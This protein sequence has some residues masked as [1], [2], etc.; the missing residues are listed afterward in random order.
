M[1]EMRLG[2]EVAYLHLL[3]PKKGAE[4]DMSHDYHAK[5]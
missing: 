4:L 1:R 3:M 5:S 2:R